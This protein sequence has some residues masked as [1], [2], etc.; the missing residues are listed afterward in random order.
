MAPLMRD[1]KTKLRGFITFAIV[2]VILNYLFLSMYGNEISKT[3]KSISES[4]SNGY[5][6]GEYFPLQ[7]FIVVKGEKVKVPVLWYEKAWGVRQKN[8]FFEET[9]F[10]AGYNITVPSNKKMRDIDYNY[11]ILNDKN[12]Q[13]EKLYVF[14]QVGWQ[15]SLDNATDTVRFYIEAKKKDSWLEV[16][17][18]DTISFVKK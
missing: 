7:D 9:F 17:H 12:Y 6:Q 3:S 5:F 1:K 4:K 2:A 15:F 11:K 18:P 10:S 16:Y 8:I 13:G 14:D